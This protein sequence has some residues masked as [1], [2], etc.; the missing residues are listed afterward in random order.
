MKLKCDT[1]GRRVLAVSTSDKF[2]HRTGDMSVCDSQTATLRDNISR[3]SRVFAVG[4]TKK[5]FLHDN[6][7]LRPISTNKG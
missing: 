6:S 4:K 3:T 5:D 7:V 1:H 2:L